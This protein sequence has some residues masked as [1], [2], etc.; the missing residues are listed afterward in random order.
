VQDR[1]ERR[2]FE[3][4]EDRALV[5][6]LGDETAILSGAKVAH[7]PARRERRVDLQGRAEDGIGQRGTR[8]PALLLLLG[9]GD[10]PAEITEQRGEEI[11]LVRL[12]LVVAP[13]VLR[14]GPLDGLGDGHRLRHGAVGEV[15]LLLNDD[16]HRE[17]VFARPA[18]RLVVGTRAGR[19]VAVHDHRI[20]ALAALT[21]NDVAPRGLADLL[22]SRDRHTALLASVVHGWPF[23]C[24]CRYTEGGYTTRPDRFAAGV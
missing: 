16:L 23:R 18:V 3:E 11:A 12:G 20:L 4:A 17:N 1:G 14:I 22:L 8:A 21:R 2:V 10:A 6:R 15:E 7:E 19:P 13:P 5:G 9:L 24:R